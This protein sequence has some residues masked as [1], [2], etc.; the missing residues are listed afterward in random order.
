MSALTDAR[1]ALH[2]EL[3][4]AFVQP[5]AGY[6]FAGRVH[7]SEPARLA[8]PCVFIG[9]S[10]GTRR[11]GRDTGAAYVATFPVWVVYDGADQAQVDGL[12]EVIGRVHDAGMHSGFITTG[13][14]AQTPPAPA[15]PAR[16][17]TLRAAVVDIETTLRAHTFC[18]PA[19]MEASGV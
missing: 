9:A 11:L 10:E 6:Q 19:L 2:A 5:I 1:R 7:L 12:E 4:T 18:S 16:V 17:S 3:S 13:H 15:D 8:A 14:T